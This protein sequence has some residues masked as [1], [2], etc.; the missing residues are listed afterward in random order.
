M[1]KCNAISASDQFLKLDWRLHFTIVEEY[2]TSWDK[3][4]EISLE[5]KSNRMDTSGRSGVV[6]HLERTYLNLPRQ[7]GDRFTLPHSK[8]NV[9]RLTL[10]RKIRWTDYHR[11]YYPCEGCM[12]LPNSFVPKQGQYTKILRRESR[13]EW[14]IHFGFLHKCW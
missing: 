10:K 6:Q 5:F 1:D 4:I 8:L 13:T 9:R 14:L 2:S 3:F 7:T 11:G 12:E